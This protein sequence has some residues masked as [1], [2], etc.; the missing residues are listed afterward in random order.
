MGYA[1]PANKTA[2]DV[3]DP[4]MNGRAHRVLVHPCHSR[5]YCPARVRTWRTGDSAS[6]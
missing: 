1:G 4:V 3:L 5:V 2:E 6:C